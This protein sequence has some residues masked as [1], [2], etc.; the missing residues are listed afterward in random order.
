M[1]GNKRNYRN[2]W[3]VFLTKTDIMK[4]NQAILNTET[5]RIEFLSNIFKQPTW[6]RKK[7]TT[8]HRTIDR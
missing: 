8:E 5:K 3:K 4:N 6:Q 2:G 1:G 7:K